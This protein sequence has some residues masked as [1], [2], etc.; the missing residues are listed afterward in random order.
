MVKR[1]TNPNMFALSIE[2]QRPK[3]AEVADGAANIRRPL[4]VSELSQLLG[5]SRSKIE[6]YRKMGAIPFHRVCDGYP[7]YYLDEVLE[8][9]DKRT[10]VSEAKCER[11]DADETKAA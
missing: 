2:A 10:L 11:Y 6:R 1:R 4:T 5:W 9:L 8:A 3:T 7:Y